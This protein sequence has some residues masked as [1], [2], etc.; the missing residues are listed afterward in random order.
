MLTSIKMNKKVKDYIENQEEFKIVLLKKSRKLI[1]ETIPN[2]KEEFNWGVPVYDDGKFYIAA[3]KTRV[4]IGF[5]ITGLNKQEVE[6]FEGSGKTM[7]HI[8]IHSLE[9]FDQKKLSQL[10]KLVHKKTNPPPDYK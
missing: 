4:H 3:M 2:C 7:R 5:A 1:L 9:E 8:K 6:Q 10:I